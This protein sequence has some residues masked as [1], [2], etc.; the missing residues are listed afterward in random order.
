MENT[1]F[2]NQIEMKTAWPL[3]HSLHQDN[4]DCV[5]MPLTAPLRRGPF[6]RNIQ[7]ANYF[8]HLG[9]R[10]GNCDA[11]VTC[12]IHRCLLCKW[13]IL[14]QGLSRIKCNSLH[15]I[16][17]LY[18]HQNVPTYTLCLG[19]YVGIVAFIFKKGR[20]TLILWMISY[21]SSKCARKG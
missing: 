8:S 10:E 7:Y 9:C 12:I 15:S 21:T 11:P 20:R 3:G 14:L 5:L 4:E 1:K 18:I 17:M 19:I 2:G 16:R 6:V 13:K